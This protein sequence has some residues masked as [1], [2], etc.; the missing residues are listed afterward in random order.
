LEKKLES[1]L[2]NGFTQIHGRCDELEEHLKKIL[3]ILEKQKGQALPVRNIFQNN[4][5]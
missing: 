2:E 1:K 4:I 3:G 5:K